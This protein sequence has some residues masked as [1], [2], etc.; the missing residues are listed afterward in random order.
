M[1]QYKGTMKDDMHEIMIAN[2]DPRG[3]SGVFVCLLMALSFDRRRDMRGDCGT[4]VL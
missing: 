2:V 3:E 4:Q 1:W